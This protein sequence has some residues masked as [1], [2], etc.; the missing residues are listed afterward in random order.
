M[1]ES[2]SFGYAVQKAT[3]KKEYV[4]HFD[5]M[6]FN[7]LQTKIFGII[8]EIHQE[9]YGK[10]AK[11]RIMISDLMLDINRAGYEAEHP[12][13]IRE[14]A[15]LYEN[16][17]IYID[18]HITDQL[19]LDELAGK[20]YLSTY[21][22]SHLFK[23]HLGIT[24]HQYILKK[25]LNLFRDFLRESGDISQAYLSS[26]FNDYSSFYRAFKKEYGLSPSDYRNQIIREA[27]EFRRN[28]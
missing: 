4:H 25:R 19:S 22:I 6:A 21:H 9:R 3:V 16:L 23:E 7:A 14:E 17:I 1:L 28:K 18:G 8:Q 13:E 24:I 26:G 15:S 10:N 12:L 27:S 5:N 20:F 2:T 11:L